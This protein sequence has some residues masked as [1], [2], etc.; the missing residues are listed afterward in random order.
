MELVIW[1]RKPQNGG[2]NSYLYA[3]VIVDGVRSREFS[4]RI[5]ATRA[6]FGSGYYDKQIAELKADLLT[7]Q[8]VLFGEYGH[9]ATPDQIVSR[10]LL[11]R[12][13]AAPKASG[14]DV[15]ALM[16]AKIATTSGGTAKSYQ[17]AKNIIAGVAPDLLK[18][19][20]NSITREQAQMYVDALAATYK[21]NT[22][23]IAA[24][25]LSAAFN[26]ALKK[27]I[28]KSNPFWRVDK[29]K[30]VIN[31]I[32]FNDSQIQALRA[33]RGAPDTKRGQCV[34]LLLFQIETGLSYIDTQSFD[35]KQVKALDGVQYFEG[36]RHKTGK[37]YFGR[38]S[39][40]A[41]EILATHGGRLPKI[42]YQTY[43]YHF[44][45]IFK[46]LGFEGLSSHKSRHT[47]ARIIIER[48]GRLDVVAACLGSDKS[49]VEKH[50]GKQTLRGFAELLE[51][52]GM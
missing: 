13:P 43:Y 29:P 47:L 27:N 51:K 48:S 7:L 23:R 12:K 15:A 11:E 42:Y 28:V 2:K 32:S 50:Y 5:K 24:A 38:L 39:A 8:A 30:P 34:D 4:T 22:V 17:V 44:A 41:A 49:T 33:L 16:A 1:Y 40:L 31:I 45:R 37:Q 9:A 19:D 26:V 6:R 20:P 25:L 46:E 18:A 3:Y 14:P 21:P 36:T 52:S 10:L 35:C